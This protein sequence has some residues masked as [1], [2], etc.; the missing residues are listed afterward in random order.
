MFLTTN[1]FCKCHP[2]K[3][4]SSCST[5]SSCECLGGWGIGRAPTPYQCLDGH[6]V[7]NQQYSQS[8]HR[9][10]SP[11]VTITIGN[12]PMISLQT[13]LISTALVPFIWEIMSDIQQTQVTGHSTHD[14]GQSGP[15][16]MLLRSPHG[17][18]SGP[19]YSHSGAIGHKLSG[20]HFSQ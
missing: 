3:A 16:Q 9:S 15:T 14:H 7:L 8:H 18:K 2:L 17:R 11:Q 10:P 4:L 19:W 6:T 12:H 5:W 20:L 1:G 13:L